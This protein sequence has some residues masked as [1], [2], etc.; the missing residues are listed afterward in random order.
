MRTRAWTEIRDV[1]NEMKTGAVRC[2]SELTMTTSA[3]SGGRMTDLRYFLAGLQV[4]ARLHSTDRH[5]EMSSFRLLLP[6]A[7]ASLGVW[8]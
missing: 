3:V 7:A 6:S 2:L 5:G 1:N 8:G 4:L